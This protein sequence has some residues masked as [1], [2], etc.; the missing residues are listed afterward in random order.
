MQV[1][2]RRPLPFARLRSAG[3]FPKVIQFFSMR[4]SLFRPLCVISVTIGCTF[5]TSS[6]AKAQNI[7]IN[8]IMYHPTGTNLLDEW[9]ELYNAGTNI[10]DLSG[11]RVT[12]GVSFLFPSNTTMAAGGYLVMAANGAA[13]ASRNPGVTNFLAGWIGTLSHDGEEIQIEDALG[14]NVDSV[15]YASEGD[16]AVR[17]M[18]A[19]DSLNRQGW[20]WFA[21]H[22][23]LGKSLE[24]VNQS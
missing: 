18:G 10:V 17:R 22:D 21:E 5:V 2:A 12:K 8:E 24:L 3:F 16:W 1:F 9:F 7:L 13:F 20:E 6:P 19:L 14:N 23:G 11:W 4:L 15:S